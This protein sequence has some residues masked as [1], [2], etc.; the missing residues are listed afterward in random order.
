MKC[1]LCRQGETHSGTADVSLQR[2]AAI[3]IVRGVPAQICENCG[4]YYLSHDVS[5]RVLAQAD[6]A[7][8]RGAEVEI[9]G[10]AA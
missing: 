4:E 2:G 5:E 8:T 3:V 1:V 6:S 10:Y 7:V 9:V